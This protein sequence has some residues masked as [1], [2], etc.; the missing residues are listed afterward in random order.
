MVTEAGIDNLAG[1]VNSLPD[2]KK[3]LFEQ[4][5]TLRTVEGRVEIPEGMRARVR[6]QFGSLEVVTSQETTRVRNRITGEETLFNPLR[7]LRPQRSIKGSGWKYRLDSPPASDPFAQPEQ[8]TP[9][10]VFGRIRGKHCVTAANIAKCEGFHGLIIFD[11]SNPLNFTREQVCDY[12]DVGWRWAEQ[13]H[14][15]EPRAKYFLFIWNCLWRAGASIQHGHAQVML[16]RERHYARIESLRKVAEEYRH[17]YGYSYFDDLFRVHEVVGCSSEKDNVRILAS[18][19]PFKDNEIILMAGELG[20]SFK[21]RLYELLAFFRDRL[22]VGSF[23][24]ALATPPLAA[25]GEKW[26]DFPVIAWLVDRGIPD[27]LSSDVGGMEI[28]A[29]SVVSSDPLKLARRLHGYLAEE[30]R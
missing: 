2:E 25:T 22:G 17:G 21:N 14:A 18:L 8:S 7:G 26:C 6:D 28:Y 23:N 19:T 16:A 5:F 11:D 12:I 9:Q 13:A 3:A 4:I 1:V 27:S 29:S 15:V 20:P 30:V 10:D 24:L